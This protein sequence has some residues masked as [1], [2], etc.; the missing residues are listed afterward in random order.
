MQQVSSDNSSGTPIPSPP[1]ITF[2]L[3]SDKAIEQL[4]KECIC[5]VQDD[6]DLRKIMLAP[7]NKIVPIL[8]KL[9]R[10]EDDDANFEAKSLRLKSAFLLSKLEVNRPINEKIVTDEAKRKPGADSVFLKIEAIEFVGVYIRDGKKH[11]LPLVFAVAEKSDSGL[12]QAIIEI[13]QN[14]LINSTSDFLRYL[15]KEPPN[16][17]KRVSELISFIENGEVGILDQIRSQLRAAAAD[18]DLNEISNELL[19]LIENNSN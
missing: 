10:I 11:L 16:I 17:K 8:E 19:T 12:S 15:K 13:F 14:E 2:E 1:P 5:R 3:I 18:R 9:K 4:I 7:R 6:E